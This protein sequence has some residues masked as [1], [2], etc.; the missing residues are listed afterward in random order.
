VTTF[1]FGNENE[2]KVQ[3]MRSG[4]DK[5]MLDFIF[6][7]G[8]GGAEEL[9]LG[10]PSR[11]PQRKISQICIFDENDK[12]IC[13]LALEKEYSAGVL[14]NITRIQFVARQLGVKASSIIETYVQL[15]DPDVY[16][17]YH[18]KQMPNFVYNGVP[19]DA[20]YSWR[21][22]FGTARLSS[23]EWLKQR[24]RVFDRDGRRCRMC[25]GRHNL[26]GHHISPL[27]Q[28]GTNSDD[29]VVTLCKRCHPGPRA[30]GRALQEIRERCDAVR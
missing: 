4:W 25:G 28:G 20:P 8:N 16:Y 10:K 6:G 15:V 9:A 23:A 30:S 12:P 3:M 2:D 5:Q 21:Y 17:L 18:S 11:L 19:D 26:E 27:G 7:D 22:T 29:N 1:D 14:N 13:T 24:E